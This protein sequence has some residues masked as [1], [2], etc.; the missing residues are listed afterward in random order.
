[1]AQP[2]S[3]LKDVLKRL[4]SFTPYRIHRNWGT[5]RFQAIEETLIALKKNGFE[6]SL[7]IDGGANDGSFSERMS[8][9]FKKARFELFEPQPA[10]VQNL[11]ELAKDP[12]FHFHQ[13]ALGSRP[14]ELFMV[15]DPCGNITGGAH[16]ALNATEASANIARV[17][18]CT[19]DQVLGSEVSQI[20]RAFLKLDLQG[21][22]LEALKGADHI[23]DRIE[24]ILSE[25]SFFAQAYEPSIE[26]LIQFLDER[27]FA[28]YDIAA[29]AARRR[30]NRA[31]QGDFLFV[32]RDSSLMADT[33]WG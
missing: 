33:A 22:E 11:E 19:L 12:R 21:W 18:V 16:V 13:T 15:I 31:H 10:C 8:R 30:D 24:V 20:D 26:A 2:L 25:V 3:A 17:S 7:I 14:G 6:A 23:L 5:N 27:G 4:I 1:M 9:I 29:L 28:L 32:R